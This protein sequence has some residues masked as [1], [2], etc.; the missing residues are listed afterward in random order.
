MPA[1]NITTA[2]LADLFLRLLPR[3]RVWP[4]TSDAIQA[5]A[6]T[7]LT[8]TY[9]RLLLRDNHLLTDAFPATTVELLPEWEF[10]LGL[11]D[12][13]AAANQTIAQRQAQVVAR[14]TQSNGPSLA[15]LTAF[16]AALGYAIT[17][18]EYTPARYGR[19]KYGQPMYG[20]DWAFAWKITTAAVTITPAQYGKARYSDPYRTW[21]GGVLECEM[22]RLKPAHTIIV[23]SYTGQ[24]LPPEWDTSGPGTGWAT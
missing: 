12:P 4:K 7:A 22:E 9:S 16:A 5:G 8:P 19:Q 3:G 24:T 10:S 1:L 6:V 20:P 14:L 21:G 18:S 11:P 2:D 15:S 13:C 23:Y 17:I